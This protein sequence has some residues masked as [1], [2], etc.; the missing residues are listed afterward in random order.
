MTDDEK[1]LT[2]DGLTGKNVISILISFGI[3]GVCVYL[4]GHY[5]QTHFPDGLG[6]ESTLCNINQYFTCSHATKSNASSLFGVPVSFLGMLVGFSFLLGSIFPSREF[7]RTNSFISKVNVLGVLLFLVYSLVELGSLCPMCTVFY[8]LSLIQAF[9]YFKFGVNSFKPD[10]KYFVIIG[11][12]FLIGAGIVKNHYN[13]KKVKQ[14]IMKSQIVNS[15]FSLDEYKDFDMVSPYKIMTSTENFKDAPIQ[16]SVFSDFECP[17]CAVLAEALGKFKT[18]Y[19]GQMNIQYF[20]YPLDNKCNK[21]IKRKFHDYACDAAMVAGCDPAKFAKVHD[22]IFKDQ[23]DLSIKMLER[24]QEENG[25]TDCIKNSPAKAF[26]TKAIEGAE[27][28]KLKSTPTLLINGRKIE[29]SLPADQFD[30][31]FKAILEKAKK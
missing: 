18:K 12:V 20:F 31:I 19:A 4:T 29:G 22:E 30:S 11:G 16:I 28:I 1:S 15:Y 26:I 3:I 5:T 21:N 25:M 2:L 8:A 24:I 7:E 10:A 13:D 9:I 27:R 17:F 23:K 6:N 14:E